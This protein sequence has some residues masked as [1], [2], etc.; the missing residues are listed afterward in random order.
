MSG[1]VWNS[2]RF[3]QPGNEALPARWGLSVT[4]LLLVVA[5]ESP[6]ACLNMQ[7]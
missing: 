3:P 4:E 1:L 5:G 2:K 6:D 7:G